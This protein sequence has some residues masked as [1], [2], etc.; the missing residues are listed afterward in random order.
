[1]G[2]ASV[3]TAEP[4]WA[5]EPIA[6]VAADTTEAAAAGLAAL[7]PDLEALPPLDAERGLDEQRF[8]EEPRETVRGDPDGALAAADVTRR[9]H[10]RDARAR[11]DAARAARGRRALGRRRAHRVGL[12]AGDLR[13]ARASLPGA[14]ISRRSRCA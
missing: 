1:M 4:S 8:T 2:G 11:P 10:L 7:A 9:A 13:R 6:V 14:S 12:D 5:G 3:L